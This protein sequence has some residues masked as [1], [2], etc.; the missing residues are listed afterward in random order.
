LRPDPTTDKLR[1]K[2]Y[3]LRREKRLAA[4]RAILQNQPMLSMRWSE[5]RIDCNKEALL[6]V[7][8]ITESE[9]GKGKDL[10][11]SPRLK[12][13]YRELRKRLAKP[14]RKKPVK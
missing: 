5:R 3:H 14:A 11:E 10:L 13:A 9:P 8:Q 12:R 6:H 2:S 4:V 7:E 1:L